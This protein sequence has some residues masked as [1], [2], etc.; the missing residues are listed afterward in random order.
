[1]TTTIENTINTELT[2]TYW[3][4][5]NL[6][7]EYISADNKICKLQKVI[8]ME[9]QFIYL[10]NYSEYDKNEDDKTKN[11]KFQKYIQ[12]IIKEKTKREYMYTNCKWVNKSYKKIYKK[13]IEMNKLI[14]LYIDITCRMND[15]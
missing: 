1:M 7:T 6:V 13:K 2:T 11:A 10:S 8:L 14:R 5:T 9:K 4:T 3:I 12:E 15:F